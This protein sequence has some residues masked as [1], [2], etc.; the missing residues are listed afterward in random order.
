[1]Q[2]LQTKTLIRLCKYLAAEKTS[3]MKKSFFVQP[4]Q[5]GRYFFY[6]TAL[7]IVGG[8]MVE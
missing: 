4:E 8:E 7:E 6:E 5:K 3:N 2:P 1:L